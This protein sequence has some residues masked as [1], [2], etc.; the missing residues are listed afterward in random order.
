MLPGR[1]QS[2]PMHAR[3]A[4]LSLLACTVVGLAA[5]GAKPAPKPK[6]Q[7]KGKKVMV[8]VGTY[9]GGKSKGI[10]YCEMDSETGALSAPRLVA[11]IANPSFLT[12]HPNGKYLYAVNEVG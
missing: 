5:G 3:I 9:T 11:E 6:L 7:A 8:Y 12:I 4:L 1:E 10:H 2:E